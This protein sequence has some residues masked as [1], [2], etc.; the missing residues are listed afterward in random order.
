MSVVNQRRILN[1]FLE[2][3]EYVSFISL[4]GN[5]MAHNYSNIWIAFRINYNRMFT[6]YLN[7]AK[8][9][10][11]CLFLHLFRMEHVR[12]QMNIINRSLFSLK[13]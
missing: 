10:F 11:W 12:K 3:L 7:A 2:N 4:G 9:L 13:T 1:V 5:E 8:W 6:D